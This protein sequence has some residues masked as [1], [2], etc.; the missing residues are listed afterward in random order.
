VGGDPEPGA[1]QPVARQGGVQPF[2]QTAGGERGG[3]D[4]VD[5]RVE[6]DLDGQLLRRPATDRP[7]TRWCDAG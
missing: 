5:G 4:A 3:V 6:R 7:W 1:R 2:G